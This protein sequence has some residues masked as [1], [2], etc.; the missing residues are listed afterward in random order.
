MLFRSVHSCR[1]LDELRAGLLHAMHL[2]HGLEQQC[3]HLRRCLQQLGQ[4]GDDYHR[5]SDALEGTKG[6]LYRIYRLSLFARQAAAGSTEGSIPILGPAE[7]EVVARTQVDEEEVTVAQQ[8]A[9]EAPITITAERIQGSSWRYSLRGR[10]ANPVQ[11]FRFSIQVCRR[12]LSYQ[13]VWKG[14]W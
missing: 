11:I 13:Q 3:A 7:P 6:A 5:L 4:L 14:S 10:G 2:G 8:A 12:W 1:S 9:T